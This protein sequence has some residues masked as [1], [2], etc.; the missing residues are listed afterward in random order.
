MDF[1]LDRGFRIGGW[2]A[3]PR[4]LTL[5]RDETRIRL[6]PKVMAVLVCLAE[7]PGDVV[8]RDEFAEAVWTDR[9]VSDEVLSRNIS[10]LRSQ[11]G[12]DV[13]EPRFIQTIPG[14][15]YR[16]IVPVEPPTGI[17]DSPEQLSQRL[18]VVVVAVM[19]TLVLLG[20]W[21]GR[22]VEQLDP[23]TIVVLPFK[24]LCG[25]DAYFSDGLTEEI[26]GALTFVPELKVIARTTTFLITGDDA[27]S[28]GKQFG[29]GSILTGSVCLEG[30]RLKV[31]ARMVD[32]NEGL[33]L[34]SKPYEL[35][36]ADV[37]KIQNDISDAVV[38][39]LV[40][41]LKIAVTPIPT[42]DVEAYN[43]FKRADYNLRRRGEMPVRLSIEL[44]R[45]AIEKDPEFGRAY[46]GLAEAYLMLPF[47]AEQD[48]KPLL[49]LAREALARA[50]ELGAENSRMHTLLGDI[51]R[52]HGQWLEAEQEFRWALEHF[53]DD[54]EV[55]HGYSLLLGQLGYMSEA[56]AAS[57]RAVELDPL[58]PV[59]NQRFAIL[60]FWADDVAGATEFYTRAR[61][62]ALDRNAIPE[63]YVAVLLHQGE[64]TRAV[65][66]LKEIQRKKGMPWD[67]VEPVV[68]GI[69]GTADLETAIAALDQAYERGLMSQT[70]YVGAL[71]VLGRAGKDRPARDL[72][73]D[74]LVAT[75]MRFA[76]QGRYVQAF[77][78]V[79][80]E[81]AEA[82]RQHP[83]FA[84]L[85]ERVGLVDYW[86]TWGW[87]S[88]CRWNG[89]EAV[90]R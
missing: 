67:W 38:E 86:Q 3:N 46:V 37:F 18:W 13:R 36:M 45:E 39:E 29:A 59:I 14:R 19:L 78:A 15:G 77:E 41:T 42:T 4:Q 17:D 85:V 22:G 63:A 9:V 47:Y 23:R 1:E 70:T 20:L 56:L 87:P 26:L 62:Y 50:G 90:C 57:A 49:D 52:K 28:I 80:A 55:R 71:V 79:F 81:G 72:A 64:F 83:K 6:E 51:H 75:L 25:S 24:N 74:R 65:T 11:L 32:T 21:F 68:D 76:D 84:E 53:P 54:S 73:S 34:W 58:S 60:S 8:T 35:A 48:E 82:V 61:R 12:D 31:N 44:Y 10:L 5:T 66:E 88:A 33:V 69:R 43:L 40:G 2:E 27:N 16:L 7:R 89:S 30:T